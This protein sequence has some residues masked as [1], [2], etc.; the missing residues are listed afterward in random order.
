MLPQLLLYCV[1]QAFPEILLM[2]K[3]FQ[4]ICKDLMVVEG[5]IEHCLEPSG[6]VHRPLQGQTTHLLPNGLEVV[7]MRLALLLLHLAD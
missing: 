7:A 6:H 4:M 1:L 2:I 3:H 5:V